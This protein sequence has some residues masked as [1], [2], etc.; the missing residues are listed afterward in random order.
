MEL[1]TDLAAFV[2][3]D[4]RLADAARDAGL[5]VASPGTDIER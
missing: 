1:G 2:T 4:Q 5:E 3:Y